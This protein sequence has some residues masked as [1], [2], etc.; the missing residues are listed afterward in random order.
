MMNLSKALTL[1]VLVAACNQRVDVGPETPCAQSC[2]SGCCSADGVCQR[3]SDLT[4]G[5]AGNQCFACPFGFSCE[6]A[7]CVPSTSGAGGGRGEGGGFTGAGGGGEGG[8]GTGGGEGGG[9]SGSGGGFSGSGGGLG[10][11]GGGF[12]G[13]GG[14]AGGG[15]GGVS[16]AVTLGSWCQEDGWCLESPF[17]S[18][19]I[20]AFWASGPSD[21]WAAGDGATVFHW[22]GQRWEQQNLPGGA[23][24][25]AL[26]GSGPNDVWAGTQSGG[27]LRWSG[28][29]WVTVPNQGLGSAITGFAV[30]S[31]TSAW[32]VGSIIH[33]WNGVAWSRASLPFSGTVSHVWAAAEN[34]VYAVGS[35]TVAV[36]NGS[37]WSKVS[38]PN[39][40]YTGV[41]GT[42]PGEV[43]VV[44]SASTV[45]HYSGGAW[46]LVPVPPQYASGFSAVHVAGAGAV[47]F[48]HQ[49]LFA[50]WS[51]G[52]GFTTVMNHM[53]T[54]RAV[55]AWST[56]S[57]LAGGL[58]LW[59]LS[60]AGVQKISA[61]A[62]ISFQDVYLASPN[63]LWALDTSSIWRFDGTSWRTVTSQHGGYER[64]WVDPS[65][66][67]AWFTTSSSTGTLMRW[68]PSGLTSTSL[69]P[70]ARVWHVHGSGTSNVFAVGAGGTV[71][72]W[73]GQFWSQV[74]S[75]TSSEL[76]AVYVASPSAAWAVGANG[77]ITEWTGLAWTPA[78]SG[79]SE[80]LLAVHANG[81][82]VWAVGDEGVTLQKGTM[83]W[84][85]RIIPGAPDL[86]SVYVAGP[87]E[88]YAGN[89]AALYRFNGSEWMLLSGQSRGHRLT[90]V[91]RNAWAIGY[92][93]MG[94]VVARLGGGV[95]CEA[96]WPLTPGKV[97]SMN[98]A[99]FGNNNAG[100]FN[101]CPSGADEDVSFSV[102]VPAG[103]SVSLT[104]TPQAF[105]ATLAL[106][107][108]PAA[109]DS[110]TCVLGVNAVSGA[111][112]E[113]L[114]WNNTGATPR[115]VNVIVDS[116]ADGG[117]FQV[118]PKLGPPVACSAATCPSGCCENNVCVTGNTQSA[119]GRQGSTCGS[120]GQYQLCSGQACVE[121]VRPTGAPCSSTAQCTAGLLLESPVCRTS[122]P[123]GGYCS[124]SCFLS[125]A[126]GD[127]FNPGH[128]TSTG[129]CLS[130]CT[131]PG[132]GQSTCRPDYVC[133]ADGM[134][135]VCVP[136]CQAL[137]CGSGRTCMPSGYC[138]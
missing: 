135:G 92:S 134:Q 26:G 38:A 20:N 104:V 41:A 9:F 107:S 1:A 57:A 121:Q 88:V 47:V 76:R 46:Q 37:V 44:G 100:F 56:T 94:P 136:K 129:V 102:E 31:P 7:T 61:S 17:P 117:F 11:T 83:G 60:T 106:L 138:Q 128:C 62:P 25:T 21:V 59:N 51:A 101:G 3:P 132:T 22:D 73:A 87:Y 43:W 125:G 99:M 34:E 127:L 126:C 64:A 53:L 52:A 63:D 115:T 81:N 68:Q 119:C 72:R 54:P 15:S 113:T 13:S 18:Q 91:G 93:V 98:A 105:D 80:R 77:V 137:P 19:P 33:R 85:K 123:G 131:A 39:V 74:P 42:G 116:I 108:D 40:T 110:R 48:R 89:S 30:L 118:F 82:D 8:F 32:A 124:A 86:E 12:T 96:G 78:P 133:V 28:T 4:C 55:W 112:P 23:R 66:T 103:Q 36:W 6:G 122:W 90:G 10:G 29:G 111:Q 24:I 2:E 114:T 70:A 95:S 16:T 49:G 45:L 130:K 65:G 120:C 50:Q 84:T 79:T 109:C 97:T 27:T 69:T 14:G 35:G 5:A 75:G 71:W 58:G 67:D